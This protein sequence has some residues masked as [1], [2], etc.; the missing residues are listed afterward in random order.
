MCISRDNDSRLMFAS[1]DPCTFDLIKIKKTIHVNHR[2]YLIDLF[3]FY[4]SIRNG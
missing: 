1:M 4:I 3:S 2:F